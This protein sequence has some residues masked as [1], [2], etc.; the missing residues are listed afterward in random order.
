MDPIAHVS[1]HSYPVAPG[2]SQVVTG[3][4]LGS[5]SELGGDEEEVLGRTH[6]ALP[7]REDGLPAGV[8]T[9]CSSHSSLFRVGDQTVLVPNTCK[10]PAGGKEIFFPHGLYRWRVLWHRNKTHHFD[11]PP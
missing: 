3:V 4:L 5:T 10:P 1:R 9:I 11:G 2:M 7:K 6:G 8:K